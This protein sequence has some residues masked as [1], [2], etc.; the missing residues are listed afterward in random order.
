M[1]ADVVIVGAGPAGLMLAGELCLAGVRPLV[2]ERQPRL[3]ETPKASGFNGQIVRL[4]R[5]RGLL[6][7]VE[8]ASAAPVG[9]APAVP[10]GGVHLDFSHVADS[11]IPAV[12]LPQ[13]RL[14]RLLDERARELGAE[15]KPRARGDRGQPGR[16]RGGRACARPGRAIPGEPPATWRAATARTARSARRP[17][18][19]SP[20]PPIPRSTGWPRSPCPNR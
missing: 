3:R 4:L 17:A 8:A 2:L 9:A 15:H 1:D 10:F 11:P 14:E 6:D 5:Y 13:P 7:R 20:A 18:S 16:R 12:P 19:R